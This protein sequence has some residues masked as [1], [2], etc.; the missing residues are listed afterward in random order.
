M[1]SRKT[2]KFRQRIAYL[3]K[4]S[5]RTLF[6]VAA[7]ND[8]C[9]KLSD[10]KT[11]FLQGNLLNRDIFI[12]PPPE[13][14]CPQN[15]IWKLNKC[16]Y[17]LCDASL[18]WYSRIR[19]F[20]AEN[21]GTV[22]KLDPALFMWHKENKFISTI[23]IHV[24]DFLCAGENSFMSSIRTKLNESFLL[25]KEEVEC[26]HFL[27]LNL[28]TECN[29]ILLDQ[30]HY[31]DNI[32]KINL[33][34]FNDDKYSLNENEKSILQTKIGQLLWV[35]NPTRP[36]ITFDTSTLA[37]PLNNATIS[38]IK[39]CDKIISKIKNNK[40]TLK[41]KKLVND[42]K[43]FVYTDASLGNLKDVG[44]Q[45]A[46]LVFLLDESDNCSLVTWQS[47]RLKRILRSSLAD[48]TIAMLDGIDAGVYIAQLF[49]EILKVRFPVTIL[50]D[51]KSLYDAIQ[52][53]KYVQ[54]KRL[55]ID[56]DSIKETLM[57]QKIH[58]IKWI[59]STQQLF[60]FINM[61]Q[62]KRSKD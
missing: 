25:G 18:K 27:G 6:T 46:Y 24:D 52:S 56:I 20:V 39:L 41:Y 10:I 2:S 3:L 62:N 38:E 30:N 31:I 23:G 50:T 28:K 45:G 51:N 44:S 47:K 11:A 5:L 33:T 19:E 58:E 61:T 37:S 59:N 40:I 53:N 55:R 22:S 34:V 26:F 49:F 14:K 15:C 8:C 48:E 16:V 7:Q 42:L 54:S 17:G 43:L 35:C 4:D 21:D 36:D 12:Q 57:K 13:A 60:E 32:S 9:L 29:T 1:A